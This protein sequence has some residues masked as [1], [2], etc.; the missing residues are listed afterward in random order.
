VDLQELPSLALLS[1]SSCLRTFT[2]KKIHWL[3]SLTNLRK[4]C[5]VEKKMKRVSQQSTFVNQKPS[6]KKQKSFFKLWR[7]HKEKKHGKI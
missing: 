1:S 4:L 3:R 2:V 6:R 5:E 7:R